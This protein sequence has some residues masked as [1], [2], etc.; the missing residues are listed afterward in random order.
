VCPGCGAGTTGATG[1]VAGTVVGVG[2]VR[3]GAGRA[4]DST[5]NSGGGRVACAAAATR[6][7]DAGSVGV[8]ERRCG[9]ATSTTATATTITASP[10]L[11][12]RTRDSSD[13]S[14]STDMSVQGAGG[15]EFAPVLLMCQRPTGCFDMAETQPTYDIVLLLD[16]AAAD[17]VRAK[18][19]DDVEK[20]I[21]A[22]GEVI[23]KHAWGTRHLAF[24]IDHKT[25]AEYHLFQFHGGRDLLATLNR[26]LRITDGVVRF[27]IVK[28][29][30]GTPPPPDMRSSSAPAPARD[31]DS[32]H[33]PPA[34]VAAAPAAVAVVAAEPGDAA[35]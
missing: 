15:P 23:G 3:A 17:E 16:T 20:M 4:A 5:P 22:G 34:A 14:G 6:G 13:G 19:V 35:A 12:Q 33:A 11:P 31:E 8:G 29:A 28:L 27:R 30:P 18:V 25:E 1:G 32:E 10:T 7:A 2:V 26:T 21:T 24:E 9:Q